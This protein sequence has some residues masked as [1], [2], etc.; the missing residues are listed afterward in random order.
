MSKIAISYRR[1]DSAQMAGRIRERLAARYGEDAIFI[2]IYDVPLG[3]EFPR[4]VQKVWSEAD[5]LLALI[6]PNWLKRPEQVWPAV[7]VPFLLL[8]AFLVLV[9]HYVIVNALD[10]DTLY[11]RIA[12]FL[13]PLPFGAGLYWKTRTNPMAG[14]AAGALL[15]L[16]AVAGMTVSASLRYQQPIMPSGTF[17]WLENVEYLVL[18]TLGFWVGNISAR[19]PGVSSLFHER[20]DWVRIEIEAALARNIPIVPVLLDGAAMPTREMLPGK[21]RDIVYRAATQVHSGVDFEHQMDRL[22]AGIDK[23]LAD[24]AS[25]RR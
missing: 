6:G 17:E 23:I 7:G 8:P 14:F 22:V 25:Q 15:G 13:I 20:E 1:R 16:I 24:K 2:D 4:H 11:L 5:V 3:S 21:M 18:I 9:A 10:L 19:L 12:A